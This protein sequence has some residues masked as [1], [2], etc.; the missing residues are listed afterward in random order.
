M[1]AFSEACADLRNKIS[2]FGGQQNGE[3]YCD[4]IGNLRK[5]SMALSTLYHAL[6]LHEIGIDAAILK[7]WLYNS[8][9]SDVIEQNFVEV[10]LLK[11]QDK[12]PPDPVR[13]NSPLLDSAVAAAQ[14]DHGNEN[15]A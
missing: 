12:L 3:P 11:A 6:I 13:R 8:F 14:V 2:H 7:R 10:G 1:R 4:F 9:G 15:K 5:K